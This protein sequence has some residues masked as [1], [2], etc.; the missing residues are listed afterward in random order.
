MNVDLGCA[1]RG[2]GCRER[3]QPVHG[4][5]AAGERDIGDR[6]RARA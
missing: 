5:R 2:N 3:P 1:V 4:E 6:H